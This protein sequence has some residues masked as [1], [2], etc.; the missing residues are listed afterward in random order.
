MKL[1]LASA[2]RGESGLLDLVVI[3]AAVMIVGIILI[4]PS[5]ARHM[6]RTS[7]INCANNLKQVALSFRLWGQDNGDKFPARVSTNE[8]GVK[9]LVAD[10]KVFPHFLA[11]SNELG[12][13]KL[14]VCP[15]DP[16]RTSA[17]NW[18]SSLSDAKISYFVVPEA[19]EAVP[20][21][22]LSGDRNLATSGVPLPPGLVGIPTNRGVSW[23]AEV[24]K[25]Q[26]YVA[27]ADG[28]VQLLSNAT[29]RASATNALRAWLVTTNSPF[30]LVIP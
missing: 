22:W 4:L 29:L 24:H 11:I 13:P 10:G 30:R 5:L 6:A 16:Q 12:T 3:L 28:S 14:L 21:M 20:E 17:T 7:Q 9:E 26:G 19:D 25:H 1:K 27:F 2:Q 18:D 15:R 23:T 8:G